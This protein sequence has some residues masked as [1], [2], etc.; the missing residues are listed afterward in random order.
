M[1]VWSETNFNKLPQIYQAGVDTA[2]FPIHVYVDK[3]QSIVNL[4]CM[5]KSYDY[6]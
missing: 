2:F 4:K 1:P 3:Y 6:P 5:H